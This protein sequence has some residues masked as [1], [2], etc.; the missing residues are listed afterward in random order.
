MG[1]TLYPELRVHKHR[2]MHVIAYG[3]MINEKS[4]IM[5]KFG[6]PLRERCEEKEQRLEQLHLK[7][8]RSLTGNPNITVEEMREMNKTRDENTINVTFLRGR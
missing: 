4:K 7:V 3:E 2:F 8:L 1:G 6:T 5:K